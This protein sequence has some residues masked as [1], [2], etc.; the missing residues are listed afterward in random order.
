M[1]LEIFNCEQNS[2][3][4]FEARRGIPTASMFKTVMASGK[5][6]GE[7]LTRAKYM[8]ELVGER[9]TGEVQEGF[10]N[11]HMDR[12]KDMEEE[13][14]NF[15]AFVNDQDI[16][17]VG[18]IRN[19]NKGCSPDGLCGKNGMVEFKTALPAIVI[20]AL[21]ADRPP[22]EHIGQCQGGLWV[23]EREW[24]D[25]NLYWPKMPAFKKRIYRD[26]AYI[27][28]MRAAVAAFNEELDELEA[29][30]R[31]FMPAPAKAAAE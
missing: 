19:G 26:E 27:A 13:A 4:W 18:F 25:L 12:G 3:E 11:R 29:K 21:L 2:P 8:R 6:G 17:R 9:I 1:P 16:E 10:T 30:I 23:A 14:R 24:I 22:P 7:S 31:R 28:T 20:E 5:G 15:Y